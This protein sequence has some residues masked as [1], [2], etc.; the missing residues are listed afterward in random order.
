MYQ[1]YTGSFMSQIPVISVLKLGVNDLG[2]LVPQL[3]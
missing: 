2:L 1:K 3:L